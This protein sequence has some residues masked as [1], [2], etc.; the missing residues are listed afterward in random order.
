MFLFERDRCNFFFGWLSEKISA[1]DELL[2]IYG[3]DITDGH[4]NSGQ[5]DFRAWFIQIPAERSISWM[6]TMKEMLLFF[7]CHF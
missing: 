3:S 5:E 4:F 2:C 6:K 7:F 1:C